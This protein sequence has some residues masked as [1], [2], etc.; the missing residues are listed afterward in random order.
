M[1]N[2]LLM[3]IAFL[4][5]TV[6]AC[7]QKNIPTVV[8]SSFA[9]A[10]PGVKANWDKEG[11]KYEA[12]FKKDKM[13]MSVLYNAKGMAEETEMDMKA[14]MLPAAVKATLAKDY[15]N[16]KI[17]EAAKI[18]KADGTVMYEAEMKGKDYLFTPEG[19]FIKAVKD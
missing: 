14:D 8:K 6:S 16:V 13:D 10:Y 15:K 2:N 5:I 17:A 19:K 18:T 3:L 12:S 1:K 9:K 4:G 7:A 11:S